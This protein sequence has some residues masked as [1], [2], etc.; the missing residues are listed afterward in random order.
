M[1]TRHLANTE[2]IVLRMLFVTTLGQQL[3]QIEI[4]TAVDRPYK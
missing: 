2:A 3:K 4:K 1:K